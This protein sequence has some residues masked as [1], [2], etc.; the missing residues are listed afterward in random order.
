MIMDP[1]FNY[2]SLPFAPKTWLNEDPAQR[3]MMMQSAPLPIPQRPNAVLGAQ[4]CPP[5]FF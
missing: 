3:F 2:V 1:A 5:V 4:V